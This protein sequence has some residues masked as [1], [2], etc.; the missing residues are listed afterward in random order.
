MSIKTQFS[1]SSN[2]TNIYPPYMMGYGQHF[3]TSNS[4]DEKYV[5][6][7]YLSFTQIPYQI[8]YHMQRGFQ[9]STLETLTFFL[10]MRGVV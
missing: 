1:D 2:E 8:S 9:M 4:I 3:P 10:S 5:T 7:N 6:F